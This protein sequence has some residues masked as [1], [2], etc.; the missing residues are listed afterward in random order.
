MSDKT[1]KKREYLSY[2]VGGFGKGLVDSFVSLFALI[3]FTDAARLS[4]A[5]GGVIITASKVL[6][7]LLL[8]FAGM[9]MDV[10][11]SKYGRFR[12]YL[13][14]LSFI[15]AIVTAA[16]F[17]SPTLYGLENEAAKSVLCFAAYLLWEAAYNL[18]DVPFWSL[19]SVVSDQEG[20]RSSFLAV[21]DVVT[22]VAG[23]VPVIAVPFLLES[24][25]NEYGFLY[26]GLIFGLGGGVI[27]ST[28]FF[29][30]K[31][32]ITVH[33][34]KVSL[35]DNFKAIV[36]TKPMIIFD[37]ALLIGATVF[38][39]SEVSTYAGKYLYGSEGGRILYPDGTKSFLPSELFL[40]IMVGLIGG[41]TAV[42]DAVFPAVF[43]KVG[44][45]KSYFVFSSVGIALCVAAFFLGYDRWNKASLFIFLAY[46]FLI[47]VI[48]GTFDSMKSNLIPECADYSEWKT[49]VRRD[50][51]FFS[52][53]VM[54]SQLIE[55]VPVLAV[56][57]IL[58]I[59]GYNETEAALTQPIA[60]K[61]GIFIAATIVPAVGMCLGMIPAAFY[62][63]T[64]R[65]REKVKTEL[66]E[67]RKEE[68]L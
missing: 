40:P 6:V 36:T 64:G 27:A 42:G 56:A 48:G 5:M 16:C 55:S 54:V 18:H 12:P 29:G 10:G 33:Q 30:T 3:Y 25:G 67:R 32:R 66:A 4:P 31:E 43:K 45:K 44:L 19:A 15:V 51:T 61:N 59:C 52:T 37:L 9:K 14:W 28:A 21:A 60:V 58:Q 24:F 13:F 57:V 1:I 26:S 62:S 46:Y 8:P 38:A 41:G 39:A 53:Q 49:G 7:M 20:V 34:E 65:F 50:G 47:G 68:S 35:K 23:A 11:K 22:T 2:G 17:V 63:Y